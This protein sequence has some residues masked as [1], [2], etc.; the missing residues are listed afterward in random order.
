MTENRSTTAIEI[1]ST[2]STAKWGNNTTYNT[3][4]SNASVRIVADT[5]PTRLDSN[6]CVCNAYWTKP[7][8][9]PSM[10]IFGPINNGAYYIAA[11]GGNSDRDDT[12]GNTNVT[13]FLTLMGY[14]TSSS[15]N[16]SGFLAHNRHTISNG[17]T[18]MNW[19]NKDETI[20]GAKI[21]ISGYYILVYG[22]QSFNF[23]QVKITQIA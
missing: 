5:I 2:A 21:L 4:L 22:T 10:V 11:S 8:S 13:G 9:G 6:S 19:Y 23:T 12:V 15:T 20:Y 14:L 7:S 16:N 17:N 1:T 18:E 3:L